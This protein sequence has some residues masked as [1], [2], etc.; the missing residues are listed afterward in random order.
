MKRRRERI[1]KGLSRDLGAKQSL[2]RQPGT[3][4]AVDEQPAILLGG[5]VLPNALDRKYPAAGALTRSLVKYFI[6]FSAQRLNV[7]R[8][9]AGHELEGRST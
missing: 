7:R 5:V 2:E 3:P 9:I 6:S 8:L 1:W 4:C